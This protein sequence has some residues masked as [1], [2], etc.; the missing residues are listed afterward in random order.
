MTPRGILAS[1]PTAKRIDGEGRL[2]LS[3]GFLDIQSH[4]RDAL[5]QGD[6]RVVSKVSQGF[7]TEIMGEGS[8]NAPAN[9]L[10]STEGD[11]SFAGPHGFDRWLRAM[12]AHGSSVNFGSFVGQGTLRAYGK[13]MAAGKA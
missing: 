11:A 9:A 1:A 7:T 2:V 5:L 13:G 8:S 6:G 4:S 3:P 12:K 10:N